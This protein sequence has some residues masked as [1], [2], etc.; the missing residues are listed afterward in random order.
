MRYDVVIIGAGVCGCAAA[1]ALSRYELNIA[2]LEKGEDLCTGASK[3]NS[4]IV[5]AGFDAR[6]GTKKAAFNAAGSRMMPALCEE[7]H[8]PYRRCGSLVLG[9]GEHDRAAL[10]DLKQRG[11][12]NG[13]EELRLVE[14]EELHAMEPNLAKDAGPALYA[15]SGGIVCPFELTAA[16][17]ENAAINGAA[18]YFDSAVNRIERIQNGWRILCGDRFLETACIVNAAGLGAAEIHNMVSDDKCRIVPRRGEYTLLDKKCGALVSRTV[19]QLPTAMGKGVLVTPTVHG[20][21][22]VGPT[23][24][25]IGDPADTATTAEGLAKLRSAAVRSVPD[26]PLKSSITAFSGLRAHL[27]GEDDFILGFA[28]PGF[29]DLLGIE[30]PGLSASP[31]IGQWAAEQCAAHL[32]AATRK[33]YKPGRPTPIRI[34]ELSF[35]ERAALIEK[36]GAYGQIVCRCEGV[37]EGEIRDAIRRTPGAKSL[38]GVKRR[39]RAGMGRCQGGFCAARVMEILADELGTDP[40]SLTKSGGESLLLRGTLREEDA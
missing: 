34:H 21:I 22:L 5:H 29:L 14:R 17:A 31:A 20:N 35:E 4:A 27:D 40:L 9:F 15:P 26:L 25:D 32:G 2:V 36:D 16:M 38:D 30:S 6:P 7:L 8:V 19:F 11:E 33:D 28:A 23:A 10:E 18:F 37:T 1:M 39:T 24:E 3:A 12:R 13:V